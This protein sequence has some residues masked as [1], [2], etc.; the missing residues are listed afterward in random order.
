MKYSRKHADRKAQSTYSI[1]TVTVKRRHLCLILR[2]TRE[3]NKHDGTYYPRATSKKLDNP[4]R[5]CYFQIIQIQILQSA[6]GH[7]SNALGSYKFRS[8]PIRSQGNRCIFLHQ[9]ATT[10]CSCIGH[11]II[12]TRHASEIP[13][14]KQLTYQPVQCLARI[15]QR[16]RMDD[17]QTQ[18]EQWIREA[19]CL[20]SRQYLQQS[21]CHG[22]FYYKYYK[23][24]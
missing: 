20:G 3:N 16:R 21:S 10:I 17:F 24:E 6:Q 4:Q 14:S 5:L 19:T 15:L 12:V 8:M 22:K 13:T 23:P 2:F 18:Q 11:F 7:A 1:F 9:S